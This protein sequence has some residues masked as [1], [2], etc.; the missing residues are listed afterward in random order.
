[1]YCKSKDQRKSSLDYTYLQNKIFW[2][3]NGGIIAIPP[4]VSVG[5]TSIHLKDSGFICTY[6]S[7]FQRLVYVIYQKG[8]IPKIL[9]DTVLDALKELQSIATLKASKTKRNEKPGILLTLGSVVNSTAIVIPHKQNYLLGRMN[10]MEKV[11]STGIHNI[12]SEQLKIWVP[13]IYTVQTEVCNW[14]QERMLPTFG[15]WPQLSVNVNNQAS[16]LHKDETDY[17]SC[18]VY[19]YGN[20]KEGG[21]E[22]T[23]KL[24]IQLTES[25]EIF[26]NME[27]G[28]AC[29]YSSAFLDHRATDWPQ[30]TKQRYSN[31]HYIHKDIVTNMYNLYKTAIIK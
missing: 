6:S 23:G 11:H 17:G 12:L 26:A 31:V 1:M 9:L 28:D 27:P 20:F 15:A 8:I 14:C 2:W 3:C 24:Q 16:K 18:A 22:E 21:G 29:I 7:I 30:E 10:F 25:L 4:P 19:T 5:K 13:Q